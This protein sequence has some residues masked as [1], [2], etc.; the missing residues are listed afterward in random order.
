LLKFRNIPYL[1][2]EHSSDFLEV[3]LIKRPLSIIDN[4]LKVKLIKIL[5]KRAAAVTVPSKALE[6]GMR[7]LGFFNQYKVIPNVVDINCFYPNK[8]LKPAQKIK[9]LHVS[10]LKKLKNVAGIVTVIKNLRESRSDFEFH[11]VGDGEEKKVLKK[12]AVDMEMLNRAIFFHGEKPVEEVAEAMRETD[13]FVL[14]SDYENSPCT[15]VEAMA[16]G[17]AVVATDVGGI[18][19]LVNEKTG[20]LVKSRDEKDLL[21]ALNFMLDNYKTYDRNYI[22]NEAVK[23]FSYDTIGQQFYNLYQSICG[24]MAK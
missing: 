24:S 3:N 20:I 22:R 13:I 23:K 10:G 21:K 8:N 17:L 11:V 15:I 12:M 16:S 7:S 4:L 5:I 18:P 9:L 1:V 2:T 14:F 19:E 6:R